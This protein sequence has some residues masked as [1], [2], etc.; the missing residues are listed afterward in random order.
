MSCRGVTHT[1]NA[2]L[3][4]GECQGDE[5]ALHGSAHQVFGTQEVLPFHILLWCVRGD[6]PHI[7]SLALP[8][9]EQRPTAKTDVLQAQN[10]LPLGGIQVFSA[11]FRTR[12][13][14]FQSEVTGCRGGNRER[15]V[16]TRILPTLSGGRQLLDIIE[17]DAIV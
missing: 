6:A 9:V 3:A 5:I 15:G 7:A 11:R 1:E 14:P 10:G 8:V 16:E 12:W 4:G 2:P 17:D 13:R